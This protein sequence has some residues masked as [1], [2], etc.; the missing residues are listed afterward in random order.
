MMQLWGLRSRKTMKAQGRCH[1]LQVLVAK[2]SAKAIPWWSPPLPPA[3]TLIIVAASS[4]SMSPCP[5]VTHLQWN[6]CSPPTLYHSLLHGPTVLPY[7]LW[8]SQ[9]I[10]IFSLPFLHVSQAQVHSGYSCYRPMLWTAQKISSNW[11]T[12]IELNLIAWLLSPVMT[13]FAFVFVKISLSLYPKG[14]LAHFTF[15]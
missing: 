12:V 14:P 4:V 3:T 5:D 10:L 2:S 6:E 11:G 15:L 1:L 7:T 13:L 9:G 8:V